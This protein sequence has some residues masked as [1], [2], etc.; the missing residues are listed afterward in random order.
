[1]TNAEKNV[2]KYAYDLE[3]N[4]TSLTS[5][6]GRKEQFAYDAG[7][8]MTER[9]T[10]KGDTIRYDYDVLNGLVEKTY[11]DQNGAE[12]DHPVQMGYNVM[13][14]RI[15][16]E[17]ITGESSYTYDA[18]GRL[19]T[20]A[21]GSGKT[22]EYFYD[23]ADN[24]QKI[25]YP[26]GY[27]VVYTY[28]KN[29][30]ITKIVDRDGRETFYSYDPLNRLTRVKR[31]DG[32]TS[33]Y[34]YNARDQIVEAENLCSCG[35]L[36]SDYQYMYN[37]A[38]L[39]T[40]ETAKEC[41]FA[42][43]K[44]FGH[45]GGPDGECVHVSDNPWQ[46]QNP[47]WQ[48]TKR[49]F[50]YD[51]NG[52]LIECK[53]DKGMFDKTTYTYEYDSVGNRTMAKKQKAFTYANP[54]KT[55]Y[56]YNADNQMVSAVVC[57]GNLTKRYTYKYDANG[58]LTQEC[59]MNYAETTYQYDTENRLKAVKD[60]QKLLMA[61]AYD[62]DGNRTF[63]LNYNP[64]AECGYGKNV[65]GE[66][67]MPENH[68]N[69]DGSLTAEG[70]LFSYICSATGRAY[71][72]TEYVNDTNRQ[73]TEVLTAYTV[74]SGAT[75]SYSYKGRQRLSRNN[76][77]NEARG[78]DHNET[79]Y[80]LYDGRG[81]VT[82]NTWYNGMVTS[83]YQYDP[84]G[85]VTLGSTEHTDFY[86]YNA[87]SYNPNTG[88]E[89]LRARYYNAD[90]GRFFQEDTYLGDI[91]DPLTLNRYAY[92]KNSPLNYV[93]PSGHKT[94]GILSPGISKMPKENK[95]QRDLSIKYAEAKDKESFVKKLIREAMKHES[96]QNCAVFM[97]GVQF[98]I[99]NFG[100]AMDVIIKDTGNY[101][102]GNYLYINNELAE[103]YNEKFI[104]T[105]NETGASGDSRGAFEA[106][107][108]LGYNIAFLSI[109]EALMPK[110][111][112][113]VDTQSKLVA[114]QDI[115]GN[116]YEILIPADVSGDISGSLGAG[117]TILP[118]EGDSDTPEVNPHN[119]KNQG[120]LSEDYFDSLT[121]NG[122]LSTGGRSGGKIPTKA[123]PNSYYTTKDGHVII[124]DE[125]GIRVMDISSERIKIEQYN[126][127]PNDPTKGS[128]SS[129]KLKNSSGAV[130]STEQW[131]LDYFGIN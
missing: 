45:K 44:D 9:M 81:S 33:T 66:I 118:I 56:T 71:D 29:D 124:Y 101:I 96:V 90:K 18:L 98:G 25:L 115:Y 100:V 128:W 87:E 17:D 74:N 105:V 95:I 64:E 68:E 4:M 123:A 54:D 94:E 125:N 72:L 121:D 73:Y 49:T 55:T 37:D 50:R 113:L 5:P 51:D 80:Y 88:L 59:L 1:M 13:G 62:G 63:Q 108:Q 126:T 97:K 99:E 76:I 30:N 89:Y 21:N 120:Q 47:E 7:G 35:F 16:M 85:K 40:N 43:N 22:V 3:G 65:S 131:I 46:N 61:A 107:I 114:V 8:R 92:T 31:A 24:L 38:G 129:Y 41:L 19:K 77:W 10:A 130:S 12:A 78:V 75:E 67:F 84:Y 48:T 122:S 104:E 39:I 79:S 112:K 34:T 27:A 36:I 32:S 58:N 11:E 70:D 117:I 119:L 69:E 60:G 110:P 20:A 57:E 86:G 26:D 93:D 14:Q 6:M 116:T 42:S 2:T 127:N 52:Q 53:E 103:L 111:N 109:V 15:S 82:A 83:V 102:M 28:D 23:E 106:G 91:T